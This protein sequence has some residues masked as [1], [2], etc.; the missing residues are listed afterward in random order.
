MPEDVHGF[1]D[2][3]IVPWYKMTEGRKHYFNVVH[4]F[5]FLVTSDINCE[6]ES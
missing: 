2:S 4:A 5:K 6:N 1:V 3:D